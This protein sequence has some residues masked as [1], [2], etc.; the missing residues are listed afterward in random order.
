MTPTVHVYLEIS[1]FE[2]PPA[3]LQLAL[4]VVSVT[5][6]VG[7]EANNRETPT[8]TDLRYRMGLLGLKACAE[9]QLVKAEL[10]AN[11]AAMH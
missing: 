2:R 5:E 11:H 9:R 3:G 8:R 10:F 6:A 4:R 1:D 7:K